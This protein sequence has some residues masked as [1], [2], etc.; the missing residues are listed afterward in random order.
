MILGWP[1]RI[2]TSALLLALSGCFTSRPATYPRDWPK[3]MAEPKS[4]CGDL[5]GRYRA[6]ANVAS[7][8]TA[9]GTSLVY[10]LAG[11]GWQVRTRS[12]PIVEL[13]FT[14]SKPA[15]LVAYSNSSQTQAV[16]LEHW[17]CEAGSLVG[18]PQLP[19]SSEGNAVLHVAGKVV[20]RRAADDSLIVHVISKESGMSG[21]IPFRR[22]NEMWL[23]YPTESPRNAH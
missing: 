21:I 12:Y 9:I 19:V 5:S 14:D 22:T 10:W 8:D 13:I 20:M 4:N 11:S 23:G 16:P 3:L 2:A 1:Q 15:V 7:P 17:Q 6:N 18:I